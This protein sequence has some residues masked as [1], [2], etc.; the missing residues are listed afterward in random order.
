MEIKGIRI[1]DKKNRIVAVE[2]PDILEEIDNGPS[3]NWSILYIDALGEFV[4][5]KSILYFTE[6]INKSKIG[7]YIKWDELNIVSKTLYEV[8][9]ILVIG[10]KDESNLHRYE[11]ERKMYETCDIVIEMIDSNFWQVFSKDERLINRIATKFKDIKFLESDFE[12]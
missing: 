4:D 12:K 2:L 5:R 8:I 9:D 7:F 11:E 10:C 1:L 3:F 6:E